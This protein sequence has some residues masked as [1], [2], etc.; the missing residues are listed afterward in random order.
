M[1]RSVLRNIASLG[2][3]LFAFLV[4]PLVASASPYTDFDLSNI[5]YWVGSGS[6]EAALVVDFQMPSGTESYA[7]GYRWNGTATGEDMFRAIAGTTVLRQRDGGAFEG[8][9]TGSDPRLYLRSSDFGPG[10]GDSVFGIGYD[11]NNNGG[12]F[13]SGYENNETGYAT[14]PGDD[15]RE[16]W[17]NGYWSYWVSDPDAPDWGYSGLGFSSRQLTNGSWDG[18]SYVDFNADD[19]GGT[20]AVPQAAQVPEPTG[21]CAVGLVGAAMFLRRRCRRTALTTCAIAGTGIFASTPSARAAYTYD[22]NDFATQVISY[23]GPVDP[24]AAY[25]DPTAVLG[26]PALVFNNSTNPNVQDIHYSKIVEPPYNFGPGDSST[27]QPLI[28][29]LPNSPSFAT[30]TVQMGRP[31][32]DDPSHPYGDDLIVFGNSFYVGGNNPNGGIVDDHTNLNNYVLT[33]G[34]Y[35][36]PVQVSVSPDDQ[37]WFTFPT[38]TNGIQPYNAYRWDRTNATW[39]TEELNPTIPLNPDVYTTSFAGK[40]TA[41]VLDAYGDSAGGTALDLENALDANGLTLAQAGFSSIDYVRFASTAA[42]YT[43]IAGVSAVSVPEPASLAML[44]L[45]SLVLLRRRA[46]R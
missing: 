21:L 26:Q 38:L 40:S 13:V 25:K 36:H 30:L 14:D 35:E 5:Q 17:F 37:H 15:Y 6:N 29:V 18:W 27:R 7:W 8:T 9:F 32:T 45:G 34:I 28:T 41:D 19:S 3:M 39:T 23:T 22:P 31:V 10:L 44:G 12:S 20:P 24:R 33:G 46:A 1:S 43:V 2:A 42:D 4:S 16:G 11:A